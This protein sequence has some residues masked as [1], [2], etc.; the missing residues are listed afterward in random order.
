MLK[1]F[2]DSF[3]EDRDIALQFYIFAYRENSVAD[4]G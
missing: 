3:S 2:A 4:C 1:D